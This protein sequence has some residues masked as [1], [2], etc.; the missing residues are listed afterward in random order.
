ML[1][2]AAGK[3]N[4]TACAVALLRQA[5]EAAGRFRDRRLLLLVSNMVVWWLAEEQTSNLRVP[6]QLAVL[7]GAAEAMG[8]AIESMSAGWR[9]TRVP[10]VAAALETGLGQE[11]FEAARREG[12]SLSFAQV[13]DLIARVLDEVETGST[14]AAE[15]NGKRRQRI[16]LSAREEE[17]LRLVAEG[18]TNKEI[19]R[20]LIVTE[21][22]VKTHVTSL[23]NKLGVDSRAR[24][25]AVA[26]QEGLLDSGG[27]RA[28]EQA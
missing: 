23:F 1:G 3:R 7:L 24:A 22:T 13:S 2:M 9:T 5:L 21:N 27:I 10:G 18:L 26:A 19:A 4:D 14:A 12:R 25:V 15:A 20:R 6:E 28:S 16:P 11:R 17:V 8:D